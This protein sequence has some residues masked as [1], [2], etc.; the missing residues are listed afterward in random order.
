MAR[1]DF[2]ASTRR[3]TADRAGHQC[4]FPT[5]NRRT[6]GPGHGALEVS[7]S[8]VAAHIYSAAPG[9]PRGQGGLNLDELAQPENCIWLCSDHSTLV[10]N[11]RG[12]AFP[13]EVL[14]SYKALQEARVVREVQ[15]LYSPIGW[16][17]QLTLL[18]NPLFVSG[19]TVRFAKLNLVFG[20]NATGKTA[21][22]EWLAGCFATEFLG[23]WVRNSTSAIRV[24]LSF[25]NPEV[26][27][28]DLHL[29]SAH[30]VAYRIDGQNVSFNPMGLRI[31]WL[32]YL[33]FT[34]DDD[35]TWL[36]KSLRLPP[37]IVRNLIDEI[38][39]FP[40]ARVKN[41]RFEANHNNDRVCL[42][43]DVDGTAPGLSLRG[44]SGREIERVF[45][46]FATAAARVSGRYAPTLLML[47]GCP[48][49][50]FEGVFD[51]YSHH[52][53]DPE[54]QFQ[55]VMCIPSR[56]LDLDALRWKGWEVIRTAGR[57]PSIA[58]AQELREH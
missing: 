40:Y 7:G 2:S 50:L 32:R 10:D 17:H 26:H 33:R 30:R 21:L 56:E 52:L 45:M 11:N 12:T 23:R 38:H 29:D 16:I 14:L 54:N 49:I 8:G 36:S 48:A 35:L 3:L 4:S 41:L 57:P 22:T 9:G 18:D 15:G 25:L 58:V 46:E 51:F 43:A 1:V 20:D 27:H 5:C 55:T 31:V 42:Y 19:Q 28:V 44:L 39:A 47:D 24:R 6:T 34:D 53:L 13:P 37:L